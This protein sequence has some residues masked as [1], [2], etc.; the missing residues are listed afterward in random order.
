ML[1]FFISGFFLLLGII[2]GVLS[3]IFIEQKTGRF[4]FYNDYDDAPEEPIQEE[5]PQQFVYHVKD[6]K[7]F[8]KV[9]KDVFSKFNSKANF[10]SNAFEKLVDKEFFKAELEKNMNEHESKQEYELSAYFRDKISDMDN[11]FDER[12]NFFIN[13]VGKRVIPDRTNCDCEGCKIVLKEGIVIE[14]KE[15]AL[16]LFANELNGILIKSIII[17]S[18]MQ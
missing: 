10:D 8:E 17:Y 5:Q 2:I 11:W 18:L 15:H 1:S 7:D 13:N 3:V 12:K 4:I 9:V 14:N 6:P 16:Q